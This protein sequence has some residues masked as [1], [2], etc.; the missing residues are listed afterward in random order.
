MKASWTPGPWRVRS[1]EEDL[2]GADIFGS[3]ETL[4]TPTGEGGGMEWF[5]AD[6][7]LIALAPE[8]AE[9]IL[10]FCPAEGMHATDPNGRAFDALAGK[11]RAIGASDA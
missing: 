3:D 11:L 9:A 1:L 7:K 4:V 8:M 10:A 6:V 5:G 2:F